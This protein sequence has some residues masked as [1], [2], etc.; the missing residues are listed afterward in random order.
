MSYGDYL[1]IYI[2]IEEYIQISLSCSKYSQLATIWLQKKND[3][4]EL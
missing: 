3:F 2:P 1:F 4:V